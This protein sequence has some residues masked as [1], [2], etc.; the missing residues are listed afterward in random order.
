[1]AKDGGCPDW[2]KSAAGKPQEAQGPGQYEDVAEKLS[3]EEKL[4]IKVLPAVQ[5]RRPFSGAK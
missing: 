4:A 2:A 5:E 1:M 3:T